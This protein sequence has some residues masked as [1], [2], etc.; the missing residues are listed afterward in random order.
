MDRR[1]NEKEGTGGGRKEGEGHL[2][3]TYEESKKNKTQI[4]YKTVQLPNS[5]L[6][7][8]NKLSFRL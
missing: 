1:K 3:R 7:F 6:T 2:D 8:Q 4:Y 5:T